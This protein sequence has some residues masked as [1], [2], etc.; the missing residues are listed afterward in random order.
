MTPSERK[1]LS[2]TLIRIYGKDCVKEVYGDVQVQCQHITLVIHSNRNMSVHG[3][4]VYKTDGESWEG[5]EGKGWVDRA[6][7][8][9]VFLRRKGL[10]TINRGFYEEDPAR[11]II[12]ELYDLVDKYGEKVTL[13]LDRSRVILKFSVNRI[14]GGTIKKVIEKARKLGY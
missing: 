5:M 2:D 10:D 12:R 14:E 11:Y 7:T 9:I 6:V 3:L 13:E 4:T 1:K 8:R